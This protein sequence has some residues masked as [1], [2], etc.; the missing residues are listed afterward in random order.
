VA[1]KVGLQLAVREVPDLNQLVPTS[2]D[3]DGVLGV[4]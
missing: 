2:R 4:W 3:D 1:N